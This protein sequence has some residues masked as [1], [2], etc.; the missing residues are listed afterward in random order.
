MDNLVNLFTNEHGQFQNNFKIQVILLFLFVLVL[1]SKI[2][3]SNNTGIF[4]ILA[5]SFS[6]YISNIYV[7]VNTIQN[8]D[9]D[10]NNKQTLIKLNTLQSKIYEFVRN[11]IIQATGNGLKLSP[12]DQI[13][14]LN[15]NKLESLYTDSTLIHFLFS[16][17][18]LYDYNPDEFYILLKGTN[19]ILKLQK[20]I[21]DYYLA[22][23]DIKQEFKQ[24]LPSFRT[25]P[26]PKIEP[27]FLDNL[28]EMFEIAIQLKSECLNSLQNIIYSVPKTNKM[29]TYIDNVI[30]RYTILIN[31]HLDVFQKYN[32]DAIKVTGITNRTKFINYKHTKGFDS[33]VNHTIIP[34]K[35]H[36]N[37]IQLYV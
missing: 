32:N 30:Q 2:W 6:L 11:K 3:G 34:S 14:L 22:N 23:K 37:L 17:L 29:Y 7:K 20:E 8:I 1:F 10:D 33:L 31:R 12:N 27:K 15:K 4:V 19:N 35:K 9:L 36:S 18:Q 16:I 13:I 25:D 5:I 28:S 24:K 26:I 21:E